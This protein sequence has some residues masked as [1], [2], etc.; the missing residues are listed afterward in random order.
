[1]SGQQGSGGSEPAPLQNEGPKEAFAQSVDHA[2]E[3]LHAL[4]GG[5]EHIYEQLARS[6]QRLKTAAWRGGGGFRAFVML[7]LCCLGSTE[8]WPGPRDERC[9]CVKLSV[10]VNAKY[11]SYFP[12]LYSCFP[13]PQLLV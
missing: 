3:V 9:M 12:V 10:H 7:S 4:H 11:E 8:R 6:W 13:P 1:M 5:D 2:L